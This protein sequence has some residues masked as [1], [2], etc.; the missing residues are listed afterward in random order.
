MRYFSK[1]GGARTLAIALVICMG[2]FGIQVSKVQAS[3]CN[4]CKPPKCNVCKPPKEHCC[5]APKPVCCPAPKPVCCPPPK[6][7]CCPKPCNVCEIPQPVCGKCPKP[8]LTCSNCEN[9]KELAKAQHE[10]CEDIARAEKARQ[11]GEERAARYEAKAHERIEK[12]AEKACCTALT[13]EAEAEPEPVSENLEKPVEIAPPPEV[14]VQVNPPAPVEPPAI[15]E[16]PAPAPVAP[17]PKE[18]PKTASPTDLYGLIGLFSFSAGL[19]RKLFR[20]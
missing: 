6:P 3:G 9:P 12:G 10:A 4:T 1:L 16:T 13:P 14:T 18:L 20:R 2:L 19:G 17:A 7:V 15:Q 11:R 8:C 5:P